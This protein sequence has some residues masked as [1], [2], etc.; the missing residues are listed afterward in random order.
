MPEGWEQVRLW[1]DRAAELRQVAK[2]FGVASARDGLLDVAQNYERLAGDLESRLRAKGVP[3]PPARPARR[4]Y[5]HALPR[6]E[7]P[8]WRGRALEAR[9]QAN[10]VRDARRKAMLLGIADNYDELAE[11]IEARGEAGARAPGRV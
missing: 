7:A 5:L 11:Q 6:H 8:Y 9:A 2:G 10:R 3:E 1:R 4:V